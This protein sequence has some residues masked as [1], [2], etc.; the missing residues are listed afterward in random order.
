MVASRRDLELKIRAL[1]EGAQDV[2]RLKRELQQLS[3][4]EVG[5]NTRRF[6]RGIDGARKAVLGLG[7]ALSVLGGAQVLRSIVNANVELQRLQA[8]L[9]TVTGSADQADQA[10]KALEAFAAET[11]F[12]LQE[13]VD[14][15]I[16]LKA[17]GLDPSIEALTAYGNT[18]GATGKTLDQFIEAV[19]DAATFQFER[20]R[21]FGIVARQEAD[22]VSF[23]FRGITTVV[24]KNAAAIEG[25]LRDLGEVQFA[26]GM[27]RQM[28]TIGGKLSNFEDAVF[29][30]KT[31]DGML[32]L[33]E[34]TAVAVEE[35]TNLADAFAKAGEEGKDTEKEFEGLRQV[36]R[37]S[38][39][40]AHRLVLEF[41]DLLDLLKAWRDVAATV[42]NQEIGLGMFEELDRK[43]GEIFERR[44]KQRAELE[45]RSQ[46]FVASLEGIGEPP[47]PKLPESNDQPVALPPVTVTAPPLPSP[48]TPDDSSFEEGVRRFEELAKAERERLNAVR[49]VVQAL[50][51]EEETAR[52]VF[53]ERRREIEQNVLD[54]ERRATLIK[55][56][57]RDLQDELARLAGEGADRYGEQL[58]SIEFAVRD[59]FASAEDV[60][61]QFATTGK[62]SIG[63]MV[64]AIVADLARLT[65]QETI[66][67]PLAKGFSAFIGGLF[68]SNRVGI[69]TGSD[70]TDLLKVNAKG[71]VYD[72]GMQLATYAR[73]GIVRKPTLF[74]MADG[75][76]LMGE[77]GPEAIMPL[78]R[79][80]D[81]RLGVEGGGSQTNVNVINNSGTEAT[82]E[83]SR[84]SSGGEDVTVMIGK[85]GA[86]D[87]A[88]NGPLARAIQQ[89]FGLTNALIKR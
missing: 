49:D 71:N 35:L 24:E 59:V 18:A 5:D 66:T 17:R 47:A 55:R 15:F 67:T 31:S 88:R 63:D 77:A 16:K 10:F 7:A 64:D 22:T 43:L 6:R 34:I 19:A 38:A 80:P 60:L 11:P 85:A 32:G 86:A 8:A 87:I 48:A 53:D 33:I 12:Q 82:V 26:G 25:Y 1:V 51:S 40:A 70:I 42:L 39:F 20:L 13:V 36:F 21:E 50:E 73:G 44:E 28:D 72:E 2:E 68:G 54:N 37:V 79:G 61:V 52:R 81:G 14:A 57:E 65:I 74:A 46:E 56:N 45:R 78:K 69:T 76:G 75:A 62:A 30:L 84:N 89:R 4:T 58:R 3:K 23:T 29:R 9:T 27:A 83:R 41:A